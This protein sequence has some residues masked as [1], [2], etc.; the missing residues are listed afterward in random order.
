MSTPMFDFKRFE[1][2]SFD[3]YGTLIDW[4]RG[5]FSALRPV[6]AAHK[7][8]ISDADL[9]ALYG[10]LEAE[11]EIPDATQGFR[12]YREVLAAVVRGLGR[13]LG[14]VPSEAEAQSLPGSL[15]VIGCHSPT[16]CPP[17]SA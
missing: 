1:V 7:C 17:C 9:L 2:L 3:C 12:R 15:E 6:L 5:I 16:L 14:F 13:K 10:E 11:A 8:R 4:E